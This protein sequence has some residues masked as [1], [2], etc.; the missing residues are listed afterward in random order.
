MK[1]LT[2]NGK[3]RLVSIVNDLVGEGYTEE[4]IFTEAAKKLG[5]PITKE[6]ILRIY[7]AITGNGNLQEEIQYVKY[8]MNDT[9]ELNGRKPKNPDEYI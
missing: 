5:L 3:N 2:T 9:E 6:R 8:M 7:N 1:T 4:N